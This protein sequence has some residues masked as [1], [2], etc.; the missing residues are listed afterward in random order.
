MRLSTYLLGIPAVAVAAAVAVANRQTVIF[1]FDPFSSDTPSPL[2]FALPLF[3]FLF[4]A[5]ALG[6][7][8]GGVV[9]MW[10]R[11]SR[12]KPQEGASARPGG[13]YRLPS[14]LRGTKPPRE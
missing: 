5:F 1:G 6:V 7:F 10:P 4:L 3:V 12:R 8:V 2:S 14:L 9:A 13:K 11:R